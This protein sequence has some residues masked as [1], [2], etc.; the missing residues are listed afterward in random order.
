MRI[1]RITSDKSG[2][3]D[4]LLSEVA[5]HMMVNGHAISGLVKETAYV[6]AF[7]NG[8]DMKVRVL[9]NGPIIK[10]TQSLGKGSGSCRLDPCAIAEAV[11]MV[12]SGP[13]ESADMFILNKFGPQ[14][15][16]GRGFCSVIGQAME[17]DIPVLVGVSSI[18]LTAF[19]NFAGG[20]A[21]ELPAN[22]ANILDWCHSAETPVLLAS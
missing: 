14:E 15:A 21:T 11:S 10:I 22:L 4:Y 20:M 2:E 12:E 7:E 6:S 19:E 17:F 3:I 1:A 9:P 8:C 13:L 5:N 16:A 18:N